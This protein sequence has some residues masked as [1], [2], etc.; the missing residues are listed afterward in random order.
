MRRDGQVGRRARRLGTRV[1]RAS[2][3][4]GLVWCLQ[5]EQLQR[6]LQ[7]GRDAQHQPGNHGVDGRPECPTDVRL[8]PKLKLPAVALMSGGGR[9]CA[10]LNVNLEAELRPSVQSAPP[11][12]GA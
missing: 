4:F 5:G 3:S 1:G 8:T 12:P 6:R 11:A 9:L 2:R 7:N 10:R